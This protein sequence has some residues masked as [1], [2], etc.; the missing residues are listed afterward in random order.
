M[1]Q[2][3]GP[4]LGVALA[5]LFALLVR[6]F[7]VRR[8]AVAFVLLLA[9]FGT[10]A[11]YVGDRYTTGARDQAQSEEQSSAIYRRQLLESYTPLVKERMAFGWGISDYPSANGQRSID[12]QYLWLAVT[13]GFVGLGLFLA[14]GLGSGIRLVQLAAR[15]MHHQDRM[16]VFAHMAVLMGL[17]A[18]LTTVYMGEQVVLV[19]FLVIGWVQGMNPAAVQAPAPSSALYKFRRVLS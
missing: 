4:W 17:M 13:Q 8:A 1:T 19:F 11:F 16:L 5:L 6:V 7:S 18:S 2:S 3:R 12:N 15:P 14:I 10:A 9:A